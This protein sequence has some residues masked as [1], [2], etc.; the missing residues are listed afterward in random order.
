[1]KRFALVLVIACG[2]QTSAPPPKTEPIPSVASVQPV[3]IDAAAPVPVA[4]VRGFKV[5]RET[6]HATT[7]MIARIGD[8][9]AE[10]TKAPLL[11]SDA[12][13]VCYVATGLSTDADAKC[14]ANVVG[15]AATVDVDFED[16]SMQSRSRTHVSMRGTITVD[17]ST[18]AIVRASFTGTE[19]FEFRSPCEKI[20]DC[21]R[22]NPLVKT[23][24]CKPACFCPFK[25]VGSADVETS[26]GG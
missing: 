5:V 3:M 14:V 13:A 17:P 2:S 6:V 1:M 16:D 23:A 20:D 15:N 11:A 26:Y 22:C 21:E 7:E 18:H 4:V 10:A 19:R 24:G 25:N 8:R 9:E 12:D